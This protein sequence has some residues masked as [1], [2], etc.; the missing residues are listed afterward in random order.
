MPWSVPLALAAAQ[1]APIVVPPA[2]PPCS[3]SE[4]RQMDFWVGEWEGEFDLPGGGKG[5]ATNRI[6]N[7][8]FG[9]CVIAEHFT[10]PTGSGA[11]FGTW[12]RVGRRWVQTWVDVFGAYI[13]LAGGPVA[14]GPTRFE[15]RTTEPIGANHAH[16]RMIWEDVKADSF[17]WRWQARQDDGGYRDAWVIRYRRKS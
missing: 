1:A 2:P 14:R 3:S 7:N 15:L 9:R 5:H 13:T 8:E 4:Y 11:S 16:Y 6:T 17:T 12:D 10:A